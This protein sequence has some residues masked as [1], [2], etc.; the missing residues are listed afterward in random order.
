MSPKAD[1]FLI[2]KLLSDAYADPDSQNKLPSSV[3][4]QFPCQ[5]PMSNS[6][7][8]EFLGLFLPGDLIRKH[9]M[10]L[11]VHYNPPPLR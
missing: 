10:I 2:R 1:A 9:E 3:L 5:T 7:D 6:K 4:V 11:V 8:T